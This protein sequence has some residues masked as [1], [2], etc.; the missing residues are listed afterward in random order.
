MHLD[1]KEEGIVILA[2]ALD[3]LL[4]GKDAEWSPEQ[5]KLQ[6]STWT[7]AFGKE[8]NAA[9][10]WIY[11]RERLKALYWLIDGF[12]FRKSCSNARSMVDDGVKRSSDAMKDRA[13]SSESYIAMEPLL[14]SSSAA[15]VV[16]DQFLH[17]I[18]AGRDTSGSLLCWIFYALAREPTLFNAMKAE[19]VKI[20]GVDKSRRPTKSE[21]G[22]MALLEQF[23][24]ESKF[25]QFSR[26]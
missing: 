11:K 25:E 1:R 3:S 9:F 22:Q 4:L 24:T 21:L 16:R 17:L 15:G 12:E 2:S 19:I 13:K 18:L 6:G 7:Q 14:R 5:Q 26:H 8:F 10:R 23:V 20:L